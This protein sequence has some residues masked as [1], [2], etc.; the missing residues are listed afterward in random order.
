MV[1]RW[2]RDFPAILMGMISLGALAQAAL[3]ARFPGSRARL[4][5]ARP[6][7]RDRGPKGLCAADRPD[8]RRLSPADDRSRDICP[9]GAY[10]WPMGLIG[11][12]SVD[13]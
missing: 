13:F 5:S 4:L 9:E 6:L 2:K 10:G 7:P 12:K 11:L 1:L 8:N 3:I